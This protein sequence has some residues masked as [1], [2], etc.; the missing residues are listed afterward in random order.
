[1]ADVGPKGN[2]RLDTGGRVEDALNI[3]VG[4]VDL[5]VGIPF[6]IPVGKDR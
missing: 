6:P 2:Y 3:T 5:F 4:P 1:M